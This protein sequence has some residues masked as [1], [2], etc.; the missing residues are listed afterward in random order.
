MRPKEKYVEP[1]IIVF[2]KPNED[3]IFKCTGCGGTCHRGSGSGIGAS[4]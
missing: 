1:K 3:S 4:N 2:H